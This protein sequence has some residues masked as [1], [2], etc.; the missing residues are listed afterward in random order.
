MLISYTHSFSTGPS[1]KIHN[2]YNLAWKVYYSSS[3]SCFLHRQFRRNTPARIPA[4]SFSG[5]I[6]GRIPTPN[7]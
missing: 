7:R 4:R 5:H 2:Y 3:S 1:S 6:T